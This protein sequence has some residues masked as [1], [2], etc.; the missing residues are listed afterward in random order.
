MPASPRQYESSDCIQ[1]IGT[2]ILYNMMIDS[3]NCLVYRTAAF[4]CVET[5]CGKIDRKAVWD[6]LRGYSVGGKLLR[7]EYASFV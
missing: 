7:G 5:A 1:C 2:Y 6:A 3:R 4:M